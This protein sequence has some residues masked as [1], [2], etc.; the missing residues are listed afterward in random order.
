MNNKPKYFA[1]YHGPSYGSW[2]ASEYLMGFPSLKSAKRALRDFQGGYVG[3]DEYLR[4]PDGYHVPWRMGEYM[5]SPATTDQD[6]MDVYYAIETNTPGVY[7]MGEHAY[8]LT[9]GARGG[10]VVEKA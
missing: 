2:D 5:H 8:R 3:Y 7:S 4:N 1:T 9:V 6:Y 10:V